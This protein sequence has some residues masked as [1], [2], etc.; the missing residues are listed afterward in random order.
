MLDQLARLL[1]PIRRR[2][3]SIFARGKLTAIDDSASVQQIQVGLAAD[4]TRE[5]VEHLQ[6]FGFSSVPEKGDE[7]F[8]AFVGADR[9]HPVAL[10]VNARAGRPAGKAPGTVIMWNRAGCAIEMRPD[11][12]I[13][14]KAPRLYLDG[15]AI[16]IRAK[17]RLRTDVGGYADELRVAEGGWELET[18]QTGA[19][20]ADGGTH[21]P[22]PPATEAP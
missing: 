19:D 11:G 1:D 17:E 2:F 20:V 5:G 8:V 16:V 4:E 14:F 22:I 7:V 12:T 9:A 13:H 15:D 6:E 18:W 10:K 21:A 3:A